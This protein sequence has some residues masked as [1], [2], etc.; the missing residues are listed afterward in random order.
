MAMAGFLFILINRAHA[1]G[2]LLVAAGI[3]VSG[4]AIYLVR[5]RSLREWPFAQKVQ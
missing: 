4:T 1:F 3:A 5:A 2:E